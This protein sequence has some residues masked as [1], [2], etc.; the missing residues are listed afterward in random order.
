[1]VDINICSTCATLEFYFCFPFRQPNARD[2]TYCDIQGTYNLASNND[3]L[4]TTSTRKAIGARTSRQALLTPASCE[5]AN[6]TASNTNKVQNS[7]ASINRH[8]N[9]ALKR[10]SID[11]KE[12]G[13]CVYM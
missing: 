12:S 10:N 8:V 13:H 7:L 1:M 4:I 6:R 9:N 11:R 2:H 3:R 5:L